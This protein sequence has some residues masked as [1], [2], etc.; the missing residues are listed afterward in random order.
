MENS[1]LTKEVTQVPQPCVRNTQDME[2]K[3][4]SDLGKDSTKTKQNKTYSKFIVHDEIP[5][6]LPSQLNQEQSVDAGCCLEALASTPSQHGQGD[7]MCCVC[8]KPE[9]TRV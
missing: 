9:T 4:I 1:S 3:Q 7:R 8:G 6:A 2:I 5:K